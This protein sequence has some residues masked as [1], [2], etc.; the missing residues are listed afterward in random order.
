LN[1]KAEV[2]YAVFASGTELLR[3]WQALC[4]FDRVKMN[5]ELHLKFFVRIS[6]GYRL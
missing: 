4:E 6:G 2:F 3:K 5:S 1:L